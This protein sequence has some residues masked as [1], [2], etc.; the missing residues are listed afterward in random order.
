MLCSNCG[1]TLESDVSACP[2]CGQTVEIPESPEYTAPPVDEKRARRTFSRIGLAMSAILVIFN[3]IGNIWFSVPIFIWGEDNWFT[4]TSWGF[5][6]G[7]FMPL[8]AVA[9]PVG[10]LCMLGLPA[11]KPESSKLSFWKLLGYIPV[12]MFLMY[13][14]NIIGTLLSCMCSF[15]TAE[16]ALLEFAMDNNPLKIVV[17]VILAPIMEE[18]VCRKLIIDRTRQYGEKVTVILSALI[19]GLLHQNLF[20]FF[21]AFALGLIFGYIY[22]RTGRLRYTILLHG[23]LNFLGSVVAPWILNLLGDTTALENMDPNATAE[24]LLEVLM[25]MLPGLT[26]YGAYMI[27]LFVLWVLGLVMFIL[28]VGKVKWQPV[29]LPL[30]K[31]KAFGITYLNVGMILYVVICAFMFGLSLLASL[32]SQLMQ[33][34]PY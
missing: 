17:M 3:I 10:L 30:P 21:Y 2:A 14:G 6:I 27:L 32:L 24:Q 26:V 9:I 1:A 20:Q 34:V 4:G 29:A 5:W 23:F 8:Y 22:L 18:L 12:C 11:K 15:G 31:G 25:P 28:K 7:N 16:N 13:T 33:F 19:F